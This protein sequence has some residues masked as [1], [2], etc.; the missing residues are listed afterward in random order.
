MR[1]NKI[2]INNMKDFIKKEIKLN[3]NYNYY[4][5]ENSIN[6]QNVIFYYFLDNKIINQIWFD[7]RLK[8]TEIETLNELLNLL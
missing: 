4:G 3:L 2:K 1:N 7:D 6:N 5:T 8:N